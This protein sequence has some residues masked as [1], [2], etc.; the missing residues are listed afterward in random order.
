MNKQDLK[1]LLTLACTALALSSCDSVSGTLTIQKQLDL[2]PE[3]SKFTVFIC[4]I[5]PDL[6]SCATVKVQDIPAGSYSAELSASSSQI[7]IKFDSAANEKN[8]LLIK[9]PAGTSLPDYAGQISLTSA[10]IGLPFD[11]AAD[12]ATQESDSSSVSAIE[13]CT[14]NVTNTS[15]YEV[16]A[17]KDDKGNIIPAHQTCE[18]VVTEHPGTQDVTYHMHYTEKAVSLELRAAGSSQSL[19]DF[20][21]SSS[22]ADKVYDYQG[23]CG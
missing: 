20:S 21:G 15:C 16:P 8:E 10:Q 3:A 5:L 22:G 6:Q 11:V 12:V 18:T 4:K 23:P 14:Y 13:S 19:A 1:K 2:P 9:L 17:S 7:K